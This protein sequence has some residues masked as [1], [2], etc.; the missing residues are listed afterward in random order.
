MNN[1][2]PQFI[3]IRWLL[4]DLVSGTNRNVLSLEHI[5]YVR[6]PETGLKYEMALSVIQLE[7]QF[8]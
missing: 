5:S 7:I 2:R 6:D 1:S 8:R 3:C 4:I